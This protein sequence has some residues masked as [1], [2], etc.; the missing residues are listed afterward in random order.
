MESHQSLLNE[1]ESAWLLE[2]FEQSI[3]HVV[4]HVW[5]YCQHS[6]S[7][8]GHQTVLVAEIVVRSFESDTQARV[9]VLNV[10]VDSKFAL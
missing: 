9:L 3:K 1:G 4:A 5:V 6:T 2:I 7:K 8:R 10:Q